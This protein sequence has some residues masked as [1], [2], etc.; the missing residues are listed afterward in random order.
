MARF[1]SCVWSPVATQSPTPAVTAYRGLVLHRRSG[2]APN[3]TTWYCNPVDAAFSTFLIPLQGPPEQQID[4]SLQAPVLANGA[5]MYASAEIEGTSALTQSQINALGLVF[6]EGHRV[7]GWPLTSANN[8]GDSGLMLHRTGGLPFG[9][10]AQCPGG[11][12]TDATRRAVLAAAGSLIGVSAGPLAQGQT[13]TATSHPT[14][15]ISETAAEM[16]VDL[17]PIVNTATDSATVL[18]VP[19]IA[20]IRPLPP[21]GPIRPVLHLPIPAW[22]TQ[23]TAG[24]VASPIT[25]SAAELQTSITDALGSRYA[26]PGG[27]P[28][29]EVIWYDH[30]GE[31]L[32][33]IGDTVISLMSGLVL[34]ALTL[35]TD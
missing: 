27:A 29:T 31:V 4:D 12:P 5:A 18:S 26:A 32:F 9:A 34:V 7:H 20:P 25:V 2:S 17:S 21:I 24:T 15:G 33:T 22:F 35:Q 3:G 30:D 11:D 28:P 14:S 13:Q 16:A 23:A 10:N 6:A 1:A 19:P 8:P